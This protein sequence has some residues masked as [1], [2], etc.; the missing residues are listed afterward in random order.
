MLRGSVVSLPRRGEEGAATEAVRHKEKAYGSLS[1][2]WEVS[3]ELNK[4]KKGLA[5]PAADLRFAPAQ[6]T[7]DRRKEL[8]RRYKRQRAQEHKSIRE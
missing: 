2:L 5:P 6:R 1:F 7:E 4:R 3:H 8:P